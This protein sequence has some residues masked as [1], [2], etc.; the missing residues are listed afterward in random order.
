MFT[1]TTTMTAAIAGI[2]L[3]AIAT[4]LM[5]YRP[6]NILPGG[7]Y[8]QELMGIPLYILGGVLTAYPVMHVSAVLTEPFGTSVTLW[9]TITSGTLTAFFILVAADQYVTTK[10]WNPTAT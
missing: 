5:I 9:A 4:T 8:A 10:R 3:L 1:I 2:V 7:T 6:L